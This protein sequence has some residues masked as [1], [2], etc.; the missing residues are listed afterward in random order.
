MTLAWKTLLTTLVASLNQKPLVFAP[1]S[2]WAY[3][4]S[5]YVLLGR[6]VESV[7][8]ESFDRYLQRAILTPLGFAQTTTLAKAEVENVATGYRMGESGAEPA[9]QMDPAKVRGAGG[10]LSTAVDLLRWTDAL[11]SGRVVT[12]AEYAAMTT[13]EVCLWNGARTRPRRP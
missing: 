13:Y 9:L 8:G 2:G 5:N 10:M 4:N 1:G 7:S 3:S 6:I 12:A 11:A